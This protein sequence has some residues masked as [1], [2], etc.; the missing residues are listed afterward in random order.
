MN[1]SFTEVRLEDPVSFRIWRPGSKRCRIYKGEW[2][3]LPV[4]DDWCEFR[5]DDFETDWGTWAGFDLMAGEAVEVEPMAADDP[6]NPW[7]AQIA[8]N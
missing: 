1:V 5:L 2:L 4:K 8:N 3:V 7:R 6:T